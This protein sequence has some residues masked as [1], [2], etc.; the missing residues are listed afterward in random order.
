M[1]VLMTQ[2]R[3]ERFVAWARVVLAVSSLGAAW[4]DPLDMSPAPRATYAVIAVFAAW[5]LAISIRAATAPFWWRMT[6][7]V[8][9]FLFFTVLILMTRGPVS[10]FFF[11][12]VFVLFCA[13]VRFD[14]NTALVTSVAAILIFVGT[15]FFIGWVMHDS[16]F[17]LNRFVIR[18]FDLGVIAALLVFVGR[19]Q[20][21]VRAELSRIAAW[22]R[23][24]LAQDD[25]ISDLMRKASEF[26]HAS[27]MMLM[28]DALRYRRLFIAHTEE[29]G[30]VCE[31]LALDEIDRISAEPHHVTLEIAGDVVRGQLILLDRNNIA[32][33]E[34]A[35]AEI[36]ARLLA[37]RLDQFCMMQEYRKMA[38]AEERVRVGRDLHDSIL[39]SLT[40]AA[41]QLKTV[42]RVMERDPERARDRIAEI[43]EIIA[44][45]QRELRWFIDQ[46]QERSQLSTE[47]EPYDIAARLKFL[48]HRFRQHWDLDVRFE[49]DPLIQLLPAALRA[50]VFALISEGV[51]NAAKHASPSRVWVEVKAVGRSV[52]IRMEDDGHGFPFIGRYDL[53]EL[54]ESKRGPVTLKER[55]M[56]L[57]GSMSIDSAVD[58]SRIDIRIPMTAAEV[59]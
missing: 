13:L 24:A 34:S 55:V 7:H 9:D 43:Q 20:E 26:L 31:E 2:N 57:N 47:G 23:A 3:A 35:L 11:C 33:E 44:A 42:A 56:S 48:V 6:T 53:S 1:A 40:G 51:A 46:L 27:R 10:P 14:T 45:D 32:G 41:L 58:G 29:S 28:F 22:P 12:Y 25:V 38:V 54:V 36:V 39:Q 52:E 8:I 5:S 21:G 59:M 50:E 17:E 15:G 18:T 30:F 37:G 19:H 49:L 16:T 4:L